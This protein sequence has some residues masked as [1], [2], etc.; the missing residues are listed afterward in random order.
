[1]KKVLWILRC[2]KASCFVRT[3]QKRRIFFDIRFREPHVF[4]VENAPEEHRLAN[5]RSLP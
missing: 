1:M 5:F 4:E 2:R 3:K